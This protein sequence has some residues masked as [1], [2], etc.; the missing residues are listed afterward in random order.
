MLR[1]VLLGKIHRATVTGACLEYVGSVSVDADLLDA[2]GILPY[3]Q[4]HVVNLNNGAR[5]VTYAIEATAG[6]GAVVLNGAAARL[7]VAG[8]QVIILA[9]GQA[10]SDELRHHQPLVVHV[11]AN[12]RIVAPQRTSEQ[13][14]G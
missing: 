13:H 2:A 14:A 3:E 4:V 7:A 8:D 10:S 12:N 5:L 9:Y 11:D 1:T 6:S